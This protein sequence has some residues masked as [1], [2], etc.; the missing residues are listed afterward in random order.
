MK[1]RRNIITML[2]LATVFLAPG[3]AAYIFYQHTDWLAAAKTNKGELLN[4]PIP[5]SVLNQEPKWKFVL[6]NPGVCET[7][8]QEELDKLAR[9]RLA[10]GRRLYQVQIDFLVN[11]DASSQLSSALT[12]RLRE[13]D[14]NLIPIPNNNGNATT[15]AK[16]NGLFNNTLTAPVNNAANNKG[17]ITNAICLKL[18]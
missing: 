16:L 12:E 7:T 2:L 4:P 10:L 3:L 5:L 17:I 6:W 13:A 11:T 18:R 1:N 9:V 15:L 14:I 8:C